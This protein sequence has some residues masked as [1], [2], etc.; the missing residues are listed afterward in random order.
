MIRSSPRL[1]AVACLILPVA[2]SGAASGAPLHQPLPADSLE[3]NG[4][5]QVMQKHHTRH[6]P[7]VPP[8]LAGGGLHPSAA[9]GLR[10]PYSG[11]PID[12][13]TYHYD[14]LRTGWNQSE[15]DLTPATVGSSSFGELTTLNVDGNVFA[16]PLMVSGFTLPDSTVHN[17]LLVA[18][19]HNTVYA[20]DAQ[21]YAT[22]WKRNL[23]V[24]Q[25]TGDVGCGDVNPEYGIS[26][27]PAIV[28]SAPNAATV[29]VVAA[30]EPASL[31]FH[32]QIHALDLGTGADLVTPVE[33][34][35]TATLKGG[36]TIGFDP[37]NQ[38]N[39]ASLAYANGSIY[40]G[41]GSHCD[42]N[43]GAISGWLLRYDTGLNLQ[44]AFNTIEAPAGYELASIWMT[45]FAP[46]F[47][48]NGDV[49]VITGNG[50]YNYDYKKQKGPRGLGESVLSLSADLTAIN[51][52]FTPARFVQL[53]D[54]DVDFGSGGV[55]LLPTVPGQTAPPLAVAMGKDAELYLLNQTS[56]G[57]KQAHDAGALQKRRIG[58]SGG[59]V[60]GGPAYYG[61]P[62]G[63]LVYYQINGDVLRAFGVA[64]GTTPALKQVVTGT[65]SA[66]YGGS[67]PIVSSNG[68]AAAT[69]VVWL[70]RRGATEQ[71][72]AYDAVKLGAPLFA[73][74][75]GVWSS[76]GNGNSFV[77]AMEANGRVYVPAYKTVTVFGLTQ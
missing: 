48:A 46:A 73:A 24:P 59:G 68:A 66:G 16:Q 55:M 50:N 31:S 22:L 76:P 15:T 2:L 45:G 35:P 53:N 6:H 44:H 9:A 36:G 32:T 8:P 74:N 61:S 4:V 58:S 77:T 43:A 65:S 34:N 18:T 54:G 14:T 12:V 10:R 56:L 30:T 71:L 37:Q 38:W 17:I 52:T 70:I 3:A 33:I 47:D 67:L 69:G 57:G 26:S 40:V 29:F 28:R 5:P 62:G 75:A 51:S 11:V 27:T 23:G 39:R 20:F 49:F 7:S 72:E 21:T 63:G 42:N 19:G 13:L 64:V 1:T 25:A 60:W 41:I